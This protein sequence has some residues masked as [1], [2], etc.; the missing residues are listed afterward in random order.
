MPGQSIMLQ[1]LDYDDLTTDYRADVAFNFQPY[2]VNPSETKDMVER[3]LYKRFV[4]NV[5]HGF[6]SL[7]FKLNNEKSIN[8]A[9]KCTTS[10]YIYKHKC[11]LFLFR[12]KTQMLTLSRFQ[13]FCMN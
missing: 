5:Q 7:K 10:S 13:L 11:G 6:N 1:P 3:I 12:K 2:I 4:Y 9:I 8:F